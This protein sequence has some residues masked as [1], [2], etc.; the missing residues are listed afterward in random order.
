MVLLFDNASKEARC[1]PAEKPIT[2][3]LPISALEICWIR[4]PAKNNIHMVTELM[5]SRHHTSRPSLRVMSLPSIPV[6]PVDTTGAGDAF[7]GAV[8]YQLSN[9]SFYAIQSLTIE[10]W[11]S[12]IANGNKA[13]ARTCEYLG[14]MEAFKHLSSDIFR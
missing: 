13:G 5:S 2:A 3:I 9:Y 8:L 11:T 10:E 1:P 14:A 7:V 12:I 4:L 6:K